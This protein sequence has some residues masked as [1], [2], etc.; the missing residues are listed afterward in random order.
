MGSQQQA[1]PKPT[2]SARTTHTF[3]PHRIA[4]RQK[5]APCCLLLSFPHFPYSTPYQ[6]H[7]PC[8]R[9]LWALPPLGHQCIVYAAA[10][11]PPDWLLPV[12][13]DVGTENDEL[14]EKDP[15]YL[16]LPQ[17]RVRGDAYYSLMEVGL[18]A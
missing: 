8:P 6:N 14:R 10:G 12:V 9:T 5:S 3:D 15:L 17:R 16:G 4:P 1:D 11:L 7:P 18:G 13:V 2:T